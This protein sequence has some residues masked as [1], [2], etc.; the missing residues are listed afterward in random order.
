M[1]IR[2]KFSL[3]LTTSLVALSSASAAFAQ[4]QTAQS[5][6]V[7]EEVI[8]QARRVDENLQAV[9]IAI[10]AITEER[11]QDQSIRSPMDINKRLP[12][13]NFGG[14]QNGNTSG[15]VFG[16]VQ[17]SVRG[18]RGLVPYFAEVP[19][20]IS[21]SAAYFDLANLQLL[22]GP[23]GTLFGTSTNGGALLFSPKKPTDDVEGY[24]V[25][26]VGQRGGRHLEGVGNFTAMDGKVLVR[27]GAQHVYAGGFVYDRT[28][29]KWL[30]D[31]NYWVGRFSVVARPNDDFENYLIAN[32]YTSDN[33]HEATSQIFFNPTGLTANVFGQEARDWFARQS[34]LGPYE[35]VGLVGAGGSYQRT[36]QWNVID[37]ASL[38]LGENFVLKNIFGFQQVKSDTHSGLGG[39]P[40]A[41]PLSQ[42]GFPLAN[43]QIPLE[44]PSGP[45]RSYSEELQLTGKAFDNRLDF[46]V[47]T[48][49]FWGVNN[50]P[51]NPSYSNSFRVIS[52]SR[53][54]KSPLSTHAL[55]GQLT[56]DLSDFIEGL[57][58][59]AGYR[60]SWDKRKT[61]SDALNANTLAVLRS[62]SLSGKWDK[63]SYTLSL[64]YQPT[65]DT[66]FYITNTKGY[67]TG[68][69]N[70]QNGLPTQLARV[71]PESLNNIEVG[72]KSDFSIGDVQ[73]RANVSGYYGFYDNIQVTAATAF[74]NTVTGA[75]QVASLISSAEAGHLVG[76]EGEF[77]VLPTA[78]L[79]IGAFFSYSGAYYDK[80]ITNLG[81]DLSGGHF[82]NTPPWKAG[83]DVTYHIPL[84]DSIGRVSLSA[85]VAW[86]DGTPMA[87]TP[88]VLSE[89]SNTPFANL[90][91]QIKWQDVM[92]NENLSVTLAVTN[93]TNTVHTAGTLPTY[94]STGI[95][96]IVP[97]EPRTWNVKLRYAF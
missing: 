45:T 38:N 73:M 81:Q 57:K 83:L 89:D 1:T 30:S 59:T 21:G 16:S 19:I 96:G 75:T 67:G 6:P 86:R 43:G 25:A 14:F 82:I 15:G 55:Y 41:A 40:F 17:A 54:L 13:V 84:D 27:A 37:T 47:G 50:G 60:Y 58:F 74:T 61:R 3:A 24:V 9:P 18:V 79:E 92:A 76:V 5:G 29:G 52:A 46:V 72:V 4:D 42:F 64:T 95:A 44:S 34:A 48:F 68:T 23:Q 91:M 35:I 94:A 31:K 49:N 12:G 80:F 87:I 56:Y 77:T 2:D 71:E 11:L 97:A 53:T 69:F 8:V 90:D 66:M 10:T 26:G 70:T 88:I 20:A 93:V 7:L 78:N 85:N 36:R 62:T 28:Q 32:Y 22:K 33:N 51:Y 65:T 63:G 39:T